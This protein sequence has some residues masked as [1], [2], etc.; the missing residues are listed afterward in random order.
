MNTSAVPWRLVLDTNVVLDLLHFADAA[1]LPILH[2]IERHRA[3]C[4][5]SP[6]T[7]VELSRVLTYPEFQRDAS[8]QAALL[9]RYRSWFG[10]LHTVSATHRK[11]PRCSDPDDQMFLELAASIPADFLISKDNAVLALKRHMQGFK[12]VT[13]GEAAAFFSSNSPRLIPATSPAPNSPA[14]PQILF[15]KRTLA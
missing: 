12:I 10:D 2:A 3:R 6:N 14:P 13:P 5:A 4:Y 8:A 7:F 1:A 11:L 9:T 15:P